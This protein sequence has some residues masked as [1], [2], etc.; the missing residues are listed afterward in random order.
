[1]KSK[2][3]LKKMNLWVFE[4]SHARVQGAGH[5]DASSK[6]GQ[7][8]HGKKNGK[9]RPFRKGRRRAVIRGGGLKEEG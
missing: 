1:M 3:F 8:Q 6:L 5:A 9:R 7:S 4:Q 2:S